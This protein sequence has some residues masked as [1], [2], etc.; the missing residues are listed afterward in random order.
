M[1]ERIFFFKKRS[2]IDGTNLNPNP[3]PIVNGLR[4]NAPSYYF[5]FYIAYKSFNCSN[6]M[7]MS[8]DICEGLAVK[9]R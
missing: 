2:I 3:N 9:S 6:I 8:V 7:I 4:S 5:N 1:F